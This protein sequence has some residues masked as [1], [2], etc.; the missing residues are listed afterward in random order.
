MTIWLDE[1]RDDGDHDPAPRR[2]SHA[3]QCG[4]DLPGRCPG[5]ANCPYADNGDDE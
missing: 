3:C 1:Y 4:D 2:R 5:P